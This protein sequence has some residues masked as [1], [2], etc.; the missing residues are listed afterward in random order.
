MKPHKW[1]FKLFIL[2]GVSGLAYKFEI[3]T[4][5]EN[6]CR[7]PNEPD[8]G[9]SANI[10]VRLSRGVPHNQFY[11][12]YF[13]N[14]YSSIPLVSYLSSI[15]IYSL[16]TIRRNRISNCKLPTEQQM[17][18]ESRGISH[19]Y[20]ATVN[21]SNI[22]TVVWKDNK[23]VTLVSSFTGQLPVQE[24]VRYD[25]KQNKKVTVACPNLVKEYNRHMGGVDFL[26]SLIGMY[27]I[28]LRTKKWYMRIFYYLIDMTIVNSWLLY[29]R[30]HREQNEP[31]IS[32]ATFRIEIAECLC[33]VK[34]I[35]EKKKRGPTA[36]I[37]PKDI[38]TD[39]T[40][41]WPQYTNE[42]LRC[43]KPNCKKLSYVKCSKCGVQL[44]FNKD[45][46]CF[47]AFHE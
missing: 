46:N 35:Q 37:P 9:T 20:V 47:R 39:A 24:V 6:R 5:T 32:L 8:L 22:S 4:G 41:H 18:K 42:R 40:A 15:G 34:Q 13:D 33:K 38:R 26:D 45:S 31:F 30:V 1:G 14:Y 2:S 21:S 36:Y 12:L 23:I 3:Y 28:R 19:E 43:K 44:C 10:V 16:G 7:L 17:K 25:R 11:R 27:K 29:R